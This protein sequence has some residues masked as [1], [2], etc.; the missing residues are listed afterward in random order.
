MACDGDDPWDSHPAGVPGECWSAEQKE[1]FVIFLS[2][3]PVLGELVRFAYGFTEDL[4][5]AGVVVQDKIGDAWL[6][7]PSYNPERYKG[8][9]CPLRNWVFMMVAREAVR[10]ASELG[11][12]PRLVDE[13]PAEVD[14]APVGDLWSED[15]PFIAR[16]R[17]PYR[18]ALAL[19][20]R[21]G[22]TPE[23][24]AE[25]SAYRPRSRGKKKLSEEEQKVRLYQA[26]KV[27]LCRAVQEYRRLIKAAVMRHAAALPRVLEEA[28]V[29]VLLDELS[30]EEAARR[31]A[32]RPCTERA[33]WERRKRGYEELVR[34]ILESEDHEDA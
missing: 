17:P 16:L 20:H 11:K 34:I 28:L 27:R 21:D 7:L 30:I 6:Y 26:L 24:A 5:L 25:R 19:R 23:V 31:S 1:A 12:H 2:R 33:M 4:G 32:H 8:R 10:R 9:G 3:D 29:M 18:E 13:P 14:P 15:D 22:L